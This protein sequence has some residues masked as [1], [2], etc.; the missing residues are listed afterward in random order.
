M[1]HIMRQL[2]V[3]GDE[4][5]DSGEPLLKVAFATADG[6]IVDQ[7]FGFAAAFAIYGL[8]PDRVEFL[9]I[10]EFSTVNPDTE[11]KLVNKLRLLEG[12]IAVY[13]RACGASAIRQLLEQGVQPVKVADDTEIP[14]LIKALQ[15][16]L[17]QGPSSW[18]A[19]AIARQIHMQKD[20]HPS[21]FDAIASE[22]W[23]E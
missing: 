8:N 5:P 10:T 21:S 7:H 11:D 17:R 3:V 19:K 12:C 23:D 22:G 2:R 20:F 4:N 1:T 16:E 15:N 18:L 13:C 14:E 9:S 6:K